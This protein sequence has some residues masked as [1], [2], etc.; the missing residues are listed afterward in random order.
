[1]TILLEKIKNFMKPAN[2]EQVFAI[3]EHLGSSP[4]IKTL[5]EVLKFYKEQVKIILTKDLLEWMQENDQVTFETEDMKVSIRTFVS[6]KVLDTELAFPWLIENEYGDLIKDNLEFPK[7]EL[8]PEAEG[9]LNELGLSYT[10]KSAIHP[11]SLKKI[12]SDRLKAGED[13]PFSDEEDM[14]DGIK[15]IF[16]DEC[17]VKEK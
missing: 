1:M 11:Q 9:Y 7:G 14:G 15:I 17:V 2:P 16:Y 6:A 12:M 5:E 10:K 3:V 13:L 4:S 8:T